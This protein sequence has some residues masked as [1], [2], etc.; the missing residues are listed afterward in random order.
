MNRKERRKL[1]H[2]LGIMQY[3]QKLPRDKKF[4]LIKE[5]IISGKTLHED[6]IRRSKMSQQEL[7]DE[8]EYQRIYSAAAEIS[9]KEQI[10]M[11]DAVEKVKKQMDQERKQ[12][13][14]E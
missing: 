12:S 9:Q 11:I 8:A 13:K 6:F 7:E 1:S 3:Q 4:N 14:K 2:K 5:N 10:P